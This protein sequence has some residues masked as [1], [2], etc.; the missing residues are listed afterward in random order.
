[1]DQAIESPRAELDITGV[2]CPM[3]L[4]QIKVALEELSPGEVLAIRLNDGEPVENL[5]R[6]LKDEGHRV[7]KL[8]G[9]PDGTFQ[10]LVR[11][12]ADPA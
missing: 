9:N 10:L 7:L 2:T 11:K 6:S 12:G 8:R 4:V 5:P 3:T 1:L